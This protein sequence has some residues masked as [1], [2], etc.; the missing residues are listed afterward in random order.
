MKGGQTVT[1]SNAMTKEDN[2]LFDP[3]LGL[4][5]TLSANQGSDVRVSSLFACAH[6]R[7]G[8][9]GKSLARG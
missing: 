6:H 5:N 4:I 8:L 7:I 1:L 9:S 2:S 3:C